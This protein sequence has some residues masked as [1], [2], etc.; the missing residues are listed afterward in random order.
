MRKKT[1]IEM[2]YELNNLYAERKRMRNVFMYDSRLFDKIEDL[3]GAIELHKE[4]AR[5]VISG[6]VPKFR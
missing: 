4:N 2:I 5:T 6:W 1:E 3:K